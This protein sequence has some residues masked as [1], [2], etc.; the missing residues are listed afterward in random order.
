MSISN[1]SVASTTPAGAARFWE[2][3]VSTTGL[4]IVWFH[5]ISRPRSITLAWSAPSDALPQ[6]CIDDPSRHV[7]TTT[8]QST[9]THSTFNA[10]DR[11]NNNIPRAQAE[12]QCT[13]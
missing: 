6:R 4:N 10:S 1:A 3:T 8:N 13:A 5:V 12:T 11:I 9:T 7:A 2:T